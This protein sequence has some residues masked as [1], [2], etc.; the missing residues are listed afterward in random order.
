MGRCL[1]RAR[2]CLVY[3]LSWVKNSFLLLLLSVG[4]QAADIAISGPT[5]STTGSYTIT[6]SEPNPAHYGNLAQL[7]RQTNGGSWVELTLDANYQ[8]QENDLASATYTYRARHGYYSPCFYYCSTPGNWSYTN[9][10]T[11]TVAVSRPPATP[12]AITGPSSDIDGS[13]AI[14]WGSVS[15]ATSYK[16]ERKLNAGTWSPVQNTSATSRSE[17]GLAD[18]TYTYRVSACNAAGCSATTATKNVAVLH[19][20]GVPGL[21]SGPSTDI[22]GDGAYSLSWAAASGAVTSYQ[23]EEKVGSTGS[24]VNIQTSM[25]LSAALSGRTNETYF[26]RVK[27][28]NSSGCSAYAAEHSVVVSGVGIELTLPATG[29]VTSLPDGEFVAATQGAAGVS[30][31]GAATYRI[32]LTVPPAI[33]DMRPNLA[34]QYNSQ[35][36]NGLA[37]MGWQLTGLSRIHRCKPIIATEGEQAKSGALPYSTSERLCLDGQ[38]LVAINTASQPANNSDY[39]AAGTEYRTEIDRFVKIV[40]VGTQNNGPVSFTAWTRDGKILQF[41]N[42]V[43]SRVEAQGLPTGPVGIWALNKVEDRFGNDYT[44]TYHEDNTVGEF[45]PLR[46]DYSPGA[47]VRFSYR[48]RDDG[49]TAYRLDQPWGFE[50]G[51]RTVT[52]KLLEKI[53]TY[54]NVTTPSNMSDGTPVR[55][56]SLD[57]ER[58][59]NTHRYRMARISECGYRDDGITQD[60]ARPTT[61]TWQDGQQGFAPA[62]DFS[63]C[64]YEFSNLLWAERPLFVDI[65]GDGYRDIVNKFNNWTVMKGQADGCFTP[66]TP[67]TA[68]GVITEAV[69]ANDFA[70][71]IRVG[72]GNGYG[73]LVGDKYEAAQGQPQLRMSVIRFDLDNPGQSTVTQVFPVPNDCCNNAVA[74]IETVTVADINNDGLDDF[75]FNRFGKGSV[76]LRKNTSWIDGGENFD[77]GA[78]FGDLPGFEWMFTDLD[79]DGLV[80]LSARTGDDRSI[81]HNQGDGNIQLSAGHSLPRGDGE[82]IDVTETHSM[83]FKNGYSKQTY[84]RH[85]ST[86]YN[87]LHIDLN[88]DGLDDFL[89][90]VTDEGATNGSWRIY[91]NEGGSYGAEIDT[92]IST[93]DHKNQVAF[94]LDYNRDGLL[95]IVAQ[96]PDG[97]AWRVLLTTQT[98]DAQGDIIPDFEVLEVDPF[99]GMLDDLLEF[100]IT[101]DNPPVFADLN[102]D[103]VLDVFYR[104]HTAQTPVQIR[105]GTEERADL[106]TAVTDGFGTQSQFRY[107]PLDNRLVNGSP[108][109][110]T[111]AGGSFPVINERAGLTV[112]N[113]SLA[114]NGIGGFNHRYYHYK[115]AKVD[116]MGRGLLG[117]AEQTVEDT[118]S[119]LVTTTRYRQDYPF[120]G[121]VASRRVGN[122]SGELV[123][124]VDNSYTVHSGN[125]RFP[126]LTDSISRRYGLTTSSEGSPLSVTKVVNTYDAYGNL[127]TQSTTTGTGLSGST[128]VDVEHTASVNNSVSPDVSSWLLGFV[129]SRTVITDNGSGSDPRTVVTQFTAVPGTLQVQ[130]VDDFVGEPIWRTTTYTRNAQGVVTATSVTG[131]DIDGT[132]LASRTLES[133]SNYL[134]QLYPQTVTNALG[135]AT[136]LGYDT[137]FG[138]VTSA[139]DANGL[140]NIT[141]YDAF[142]RVEAQE[143]ADTSLTQVNSYYCDTG[144]ISCPA[145]AVYAVITEVSHDALPGQLAQPR[146]TVYYDS[147]GREVRREQLSLNGGS[148]KVDTEYTATGKLYRVSEPFT[149]ASATAWSSYS[150]DDLGRVVTETPAAGGSVVTSY[151]ADASYGERIWRQQTVDGPNGS[152]LRNHYRYRNSLGQVVRVSDPDATPVDYLYDSQGNLAQ[153]QVNG[154]VATQVTISHDLAGNKTR[155]V[156]PDAGQID[157]DYDALGQARRQ[158][159]AKGT[160]DEKSM[161]QVYDFLGRQISRT[162]TAA[163]GSSVT[164]TWLYDTIMLGQLSSRTNPGFSE[165]YSYDSVG[166]LQSSTTTITGLGTR[167]FSYGYDAFSREQTVTYPGGLQLQ[168]HYHARGYHHATLDITDSA[169]P[170]ILW[171]LGEYQDGRGNLTDELFGNGVHTRTGYASDSGLVT[172]IRSGRT[173]GTAEFANDFAADIQALSYNY[174]SLGNLYSR[175]SAREDASGVAEEALTESFTYD[176]LNRLDTATTTG[177][178]G[179]DRLIDYDYDALGNLTA[180]SDIGALSYTQSGNAGVHAVTDAMGFSYQYDAYGN[181]TSRAGV[182]VDYDVFNKPTRI[183]NTHFSYGPDRSRF[184][185]VN[186]SA[187]TYYLGGGRFEE[188]VSA[189]GTVQKSYV[190]GYLLHSQSGGSSETQYLHR[191]HLGSVEA[192]T[193]IAGNRL[194]RLAYSPHG[195][196]RMSDWED[197][198][199]TNSDPLAL[200]TTEGFT[201]HEML[202]QLGLIHMNGRVFDPTIGRFMSADLLVQAPYNT[203]SFNRY[204]Y[205]FNNPL[206]FVDPSGYATCWRTPTGTK[207]L[208]PDPPEKLEAAKRSYQQRMEKLRSEE[209]AGLLAALSY[210]GYVGQPWYVSNFAG[211]NSWTSGNEVFARSQ[212]LHE[213]HAVGG[214]EEYSEEVDGALKVAIGALLLVEHSRK[215]GATNKTRKT[216]FSEAREKGGIPKSQQPDRVRHERLEDQPGN[217]Q[218]RVYEY[219]RREDGASVTIKEHSLGHTKGNVDPH[220]NTIVRPRGGG[221]KQPLKN[222]ADHHTF[223]NP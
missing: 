125:G 118:A 68:S 42:T 31:T 215:K 120:V 35:G 131:G 22:D 14:A 65:D 223:F 59:A 127:E 45:Y 187:T 20:P 208:E 139:V 97:S 74:G 111:E 148:V 218:S 140:S 147:L 168:H 47:A 19:P 123:E 121:L 221:A 60:C 1:M 170:Q 110:E 165:N 126:Y 26:Y 12:S 203:Q 173:L 163:D 134:D 180:R 155:I 143:A 177:L 136:S 209:I 66:I 206:S 25:A 122:T 181:M 189:S 94:P 151:S 88:G 175:T 101:N 96:K 210:M 138:S 186:D 190:G 220:F 99:Q 23:L 21:I 167:S 30:P 33:N 149:G 62:P 160:P 43:D 53:T 217:V 29:S 179:A 130:A 5:A 116:V 185:Q 191:D 80:D 197:G 192:I 204:S 135:H 184:K 202:D 106:L 73:L 67:S 24:W 40:S 214:L 82:D 44:V 103:G 133:H 213:G 132:S 85:Y 182:S 124:I 115:G 146:T 200:P 104:N 129:D 154:N 46:V 17:N 107:S 93:G 207:C 102:G 83:S 41:G 7:Q 119:N 90:R 16:L 194:E 169:S 183:G 18:G 56:Y 84:Y 48:D 76:W 114:S 9:W 37:G 157:F 78:E 144:A 105:Y 212:E 57:Y 58:G 70:Q 49:N 55:E 152:S 4:A 2:N 61:F 71:P 117:F 15:N 198:D 10:V 69:D 81:F 196:R 51:G 64:T 219:T 100:N 6:V 98:T 113:E 145:Q 28:C 199:P 205:V 172:S 87:G 178:S 211:L 13:F 156:D 108:V 3:G 79:N 164:N 128:V 95:D 32:A 193:D 86:N 112:V 188:V 39:W 161:T 38:K 174:D 75:Y 137:R 34:L 166:R 153:T 50:A 159:W 63:H 222:N 171:V 8:R 158:I 150:Y 92:G 176:A 195:L 142:G 27:A 201:G 11:H 72:D 77:P 54:I 52:S 162:D 216:A 141:L 91:L 36:G 109:Y 89:V